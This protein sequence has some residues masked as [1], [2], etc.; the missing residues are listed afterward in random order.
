MNDVLPKPFT[1]ENLLSMLEVRPGLEVYSVPRHR[2]VT[3]T[4]RAKSKS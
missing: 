4:D 2:Q 1:K 3:E